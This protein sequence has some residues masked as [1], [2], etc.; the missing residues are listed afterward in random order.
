[1]QKEQPGRSSRMEEELHQ[2]LR[3][4]VFSIRSVQSG[5]I[6]AGNKDAPELETAY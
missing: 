2:V 4:P 5:T 6:A 1:V 3:D